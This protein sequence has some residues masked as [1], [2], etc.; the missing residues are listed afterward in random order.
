[1][2]WRSVLLGRAVCSLGQ[3]DRGRP[4]DEL[5]AQ[6][7]VRVASRVAR[8]VDLVENELEGVPSRLDNGLGD[9]RQA[10]RRGDRGVVEAHD[11]DV[12]AGR[13]PSSTE[14]TERE[15][16]ARADEGR[17]ASRKEVFA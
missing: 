8:A 5:G 12:R 11:G 10:D 9:A 6:Q 13:A 4:D 7:D 17:R 16:V 2:S 14:G 15:R 3:R 1:E